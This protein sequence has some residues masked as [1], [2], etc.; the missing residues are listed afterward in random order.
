MSGVEIS[1]GVDK[2]K[3]PRKKLIVT[4]FEKKIAKDGSYDLIELKSE[5]ISESGIFL[6]TED[7]SL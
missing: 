3:F 5:N 1:S 2:R 4:V 6:R 7:L